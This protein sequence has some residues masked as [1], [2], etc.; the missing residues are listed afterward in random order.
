MLWLRLVSPRC[1]LIYWMRTPWTTD[2]VDHWSLQIAS[3]CHVNW[4]GTLGS[5]RYLNRHVWMNLVSNSGS[6]SIQRWGQGQNCFKICS[7][8]NM[9]ECHL[10][11]CTLAEIWCSCLKMFL[12]F[13]VVWVVNIRYT[14]IPQDGLQH[15]LKTNKQH[16][17]YIQSLYYYDSHV[18]VHTDLN[19]L[20][21]LHVFR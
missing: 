4:I 7:F 19:K 9:A 1:W 21:S 20:C 10:W 18:M 5:P 15:V 12:W 6:I 3:N 11:R 14:G 13:G 2:F 16:H 17:N 8:W